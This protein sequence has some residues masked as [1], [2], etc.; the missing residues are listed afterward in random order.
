MW[1]N[2]Y[3]L[4][5]TNWDSE[6]LAYVHDDLIHYDGEFHS[7]DLL[8]FQVKPDPHQPPRVSLYCSGFADRVVSAACQVAVRSVTATQLSKNPR[9]HPPVLGLE[10][11]LPATDSHRSL[12]RRMTIQPR[13]E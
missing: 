6:L 12:R 10:Q 11:S 13:M 1:Q 8:G 3:D 2:C 9:L 5:K 7:R 4:V